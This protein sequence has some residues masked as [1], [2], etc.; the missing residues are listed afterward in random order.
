MRMLSLVVVASIIVGIVARNGIVD[1]ASAN[2]RIGAWNGGFLNDDM[3]AKPT[4]KR[5][6]I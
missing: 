6:L 5:A 1:G 2:E 3:N 4:E